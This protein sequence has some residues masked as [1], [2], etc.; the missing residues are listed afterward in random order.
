MDLVTE[1]VYY[2]FLVPMTVPVFLFF[3]YWRWMG[4]EFFVNN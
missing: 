1:L 4:Y 2:A 3:A